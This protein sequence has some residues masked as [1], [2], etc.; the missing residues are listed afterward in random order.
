MGS[1][2]GLERRLPDGTRSLFDSRACRLCR[3][4]ELAIAAAISRESEGCGSGDDRADRV[5]IHGADHR[6][7]GA[8]AR[9]S[10]VQAYTGA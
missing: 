7:E 6:R 10:L 5:Q 2:P 9:A 4:S 1:L 8:N 3:M